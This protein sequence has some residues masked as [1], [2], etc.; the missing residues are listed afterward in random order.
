MHQRILMGHALFFLTTVACAYQSHISDHATTINYPFYQ[1]LFG[2]GGTMY[3]DH[4]KQRG[5]KLF[6]ES[7]GGPQ[8]VIAHGKPRNSSDLMV[9]MNFGYN[10]FSLAMNKQL[11]VMIATE[12]ESYYLKNTIKGHLK[13]QNSAFPNQTFYD[14]FPTHTGTLL[15]N[16]VVNFN[17]RRAPSIHPFLGAG[18]GTAMLTI[19]AADSAQRNP[20]EPG[21]NHFNLNTKSFNWVFAAQIKAGMKVALADQWRLVA[22]Y[23]HLFL[24]PANFNFGGT[25][26]PTHIP[27]TN[28]TVNYAST[29]SDMGSI[30]IE[31]S[32]C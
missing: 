19:T 28:W 24:A 5:T 3:L 31:Y 26:Y 8:I 4:F 13:N 17:I 18:I 2:G 7:A 27:T 25:Q 29:G 1:T 23:R 6:P 12:V 16:S 20:A 14:S 32:W 15:F 21:I 10:Y 11:G 9:G 30:G 22:E